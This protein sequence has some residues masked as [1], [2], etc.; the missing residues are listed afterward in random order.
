MWESLD[1]KRQ[2]AKTVTSVSALWK[3][4]RNLNEN[5]P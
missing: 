3:V 1:L 5:E 2:N 4:E